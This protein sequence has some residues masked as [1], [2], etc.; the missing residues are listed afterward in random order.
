MRAT[1]NGERIACPDCGAAPGARCVDRRVW[2]DVWIHSAR[3][4][5]AGIILRLPVEQ[6]LAEV[7][8]D[9]IGGIHDPGGHSEAD[10]RP[11]C[12]RPGGRQCVD[13]E[14]CVTPLR[15]GR[16]GPPCRCRRST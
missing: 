15:C 9:D 11:P 8:A 10:V 2:G 7:T 5:A 1:L 6:L 4:R 13:S 12:L 14:D 16:S 3:T